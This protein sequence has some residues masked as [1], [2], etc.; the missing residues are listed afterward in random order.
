MRSRL[1]RYVL[2]SKKKRCASHVNTRRTSVRN[3]VGNMNLVRHGMYGRR[4]VV[5]PG[6]ICGE[7]CDISGR[8]KEERL[9]SVVNPAAYRGHLHRNVAAPRDIVGAGEK[10]RTMS[11]TIFTGSSAVKREMAA[12]WA[13]AGGVNGT[14]RRLPSCRDDPARV[15]AGVDCSLAQCGTC[16]YVQTC[17]CYS[18]WQRAR[19]HEYVARFTCRL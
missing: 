1:K 13:S 8:R 19:R 2:T 18:E 3:A 14:Y 5:F 12:R 17:K 11:P 10:S 16:M 7:M 15:A 6:I 4:T 9:P